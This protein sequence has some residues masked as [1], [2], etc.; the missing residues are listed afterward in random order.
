MSLLRPS[1]AVLVYAA[2]LAVALPQTSFD[3]LLQNLNPESRVTDTAKVLSDV[4]K[5]Q[6]ER[7]LADLERATTVEIAVVALPS[8]QGGEIS[9]FANRLFERW[10][11]GKRGK[12]NGILLLAA[13]ED[14][15]VWIEVGYGLESLIPDARAG[16]ILDEALIP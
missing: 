5:Q 10:G 4:Q 14:R 7:L 8:L 11:I 1:F 16:R 12:N 6:L 13:V 15:K 2:T 9:D 3:Q